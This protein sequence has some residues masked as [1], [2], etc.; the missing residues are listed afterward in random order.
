MFFFAHFILQYWD[1]RLAT[2]SSWCRDILVGC[3]QVRVFPFFKPVL[4]VMP[5]GMVQDFAVV[6]LCRIMLPVD[7]V[8]WVSASLV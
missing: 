2:I 5:F 8:V 4:P 1:L 7:I 3:S 6:F